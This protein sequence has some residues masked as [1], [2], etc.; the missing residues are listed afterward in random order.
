MEPRPG[1]PTLEQVRGCVAANVQP[2][3]PTRAPLASVRG[4]ILREEGCTS[5]DMPAFDRS[6]MDGYAI[7][8]EDRSKKFR[9]VGEVRPGTTPEFDL[10]VGECVRIFTGAE[11]PAGAIKVLKQEDV[12][13]EGGWVTQERP[14]AAEYIRRRGEDAPAGACLL[15]SGM[16]LGVAEIALLASLGIVEPLVTPRCRAAHFA[17]GDELVDP[18]DQPGTSQIRDSNS[19]LVRAFTESHGG[20]MAQQGRVADDAELLTEKA[21][22]AMDAGCDLLLISGGAS[23]GAYDFGRVALERLGFQMHFEKLNLRPG[24]PLAFATRGRQAA[25]VLPGNPLSH[26]AVLHCV[27]RVAF[28][29]MAGAEP[30]WR[31]LNARLRAGIHIGGDGRDTLWPGRIDLE[32]GEPVVEAL[33]WSSSGDITGLAGLNAF[34]RC[35]APMLDSGARVPCILLHG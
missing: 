14:C 10:R 8:G 33:R 32:E 21:R 27:V 19:S 28:E 24:R 25:F 16:R 23:V 30:E 26:L 12:R 22:I 31:F 1:I 9:I 7:G 34:I 18:A 4:R 35:N 15:R 5:Q 3:E 29:R 17:T 2:L 6:A 13:S 11:I 20:V